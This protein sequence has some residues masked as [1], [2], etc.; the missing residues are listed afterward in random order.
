MFKGDLNAYNFSFGYGNKV[1]IVEIFKLGSEY[2]HIIHMQHSKSYQ[3]KYY[4]KH[5]AS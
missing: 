1:T 3:S 2:V 4:Y 5:Y